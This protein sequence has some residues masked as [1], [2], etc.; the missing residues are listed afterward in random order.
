M[1]CNFVRYLAIEMER[2]LAKVATTEQGRGTY[3]C[4]VTRTRVRFS[5]GFLSTRVQSTLAFTQL[6]HG[7]N[8]S[9]RIYNT[10]RKLR[11]PEVTFCI[12]VSC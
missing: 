6:E 3:Y 12:T 7:Y 10:A 11:L 1:P 5:L 2:A 9:Q 8:L 4:G